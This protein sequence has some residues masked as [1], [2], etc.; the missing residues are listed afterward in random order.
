M[1]ERLQRHKQKPDGWG[2][3]VLLYHFDAEYLLGLYYLMSATVPSTQAHNFVVVG[4][5]SLNYTG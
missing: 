5:L 2:F 4:V 3:R 1:G